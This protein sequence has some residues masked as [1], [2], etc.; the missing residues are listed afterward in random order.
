MSNLKE[1][2][3][4]RLEKQQICHLCA[5]RLNSRKVAGPVCLIL[6][7]LLLES[8][9]QPSVHEPS[10]VTL[11]F[12]DQQ[13]VSKQYV[14]EY[15]EELKQFTQQTGIR[16]NF[17][18]SP[19]STRD[20]LA[21]RQDL[22]GTGASG[23]DVYTI[24]VIWPG[25]L[26]ES[27]ID[28]KPYFADEISRD[29][30]AVVAAYTVDNKVVALPYRVNLGLLFYRTDLLRQYGYRGPPRTWD[31]LETMAARIQ[32][33]ERAHGNKEFWGFVWEGAAVESLTCNAMEWQ[34]AEAGGRVIEQ[35]K[36]I[37]VNNPRAI[38]AW[39]RAAGWVGSISPPS[40]IAYN[41]WDAQNVWIAGNAAFMRSWTIAY[42][43]SQAPGSP[44]R[45]R[46]DVSLLPGNQAGRVSV[47][48]GS[49][50]AV[51]RFSSH[52]REALELIRFLTSEDIQARRSRV[53]SG[54]PTLPQPY[55]AIRGSEPNHYSDLTTQ[56]LRNG[57]ISRP[58]NVTGKKYED[59]SNAYMQAVHSVL[60]GEKSA[61][62]AAAALEQELIRITG[63]KTGPP[64]AG[65][66]HMEATFEAKPLDDHD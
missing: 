62:E 45:N 63:F 56:A 38:Q 15:Q 65:L 18:P 36:T 37:S 12:A 31:E 32:A 39:Q 42:A 61:R 47:L 5:G 43:S 48:G 66:H 9:A 49:G 23:P 50:L 24:D 59:V 21:F 51:S 28:L 16:V 57:M 60:T 64:P 52:P 46:F 53:L 34:A 26:N 6:L 29:F 8:C 44:I 25:I 19:E 33:G 41:D 54:P 7:S 1:A 20:Q 27:F 30:P 40:V 3:N 2:R 55:E 14:E 4:G 17:P 35:D 22:L 13:W 11:T 58:W 10:S